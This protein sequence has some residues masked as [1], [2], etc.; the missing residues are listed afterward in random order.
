MTAAARWAAIDYYVVLGVERSAPQDEIR[1]AG[2]K[3]ALKW[4]PDR[5]RDDPR[6][7]E[8][9]KI[10]NEALEVLGNEKRRAEYDRARAS[11]AADPPRRERASTPTA[12]PG[13]VDFG[14]LREGATSAEKQVSFFAGDAPANVFVQSE[15]G[16]F[17]RLTNLRAPLPDERSDPREFLRCW[18]V[19]NT[20]PGSS[21]GRR[22]DALVFD[23]DGHEVRVGL[24]LRVLA[25]PAPP[26]TGTTPPRAGTAPPRAGTAWTPPPPRTPPPTP[27]PPVSRPSPRR[28]SGRRRVTVAAAIIALIVFVAWMSSRPSGNSGSPLLTAPATTQSSSA[29]TTGAEIASGS[30]H[31]QSVA[32]GS[33]HHTPSSR[34]HTTHVASKLNGSSGQ[35]QT[36][37]STT[38]TGLGIS[39]NPGPSQTTTTAATTTGGGTRSTPGQT[40]GTG[41]GAG[42]NGFTGAAGGGGSPGSSPGFTGQAGGGGS[43]G[44]GNSNAFSG[45]PG[46]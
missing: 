46:Q 17:W 34:T 21:P 14:D 3:L 9:M 22:E 37:A 27:P 10:I 30:S 16:S 19:G 12:S 23:F 6:A 38:T 4:R 42:G 18:L 15:R 8:R 36:Y 1:R 5:N 20:P 40:T 2:R 25:T 45:T 11:A 39:G 28:R 33:N 13:T 35:K 44:G 32:A 24:R 41:Q 43:S 29:T 26:R 7:A 31:T